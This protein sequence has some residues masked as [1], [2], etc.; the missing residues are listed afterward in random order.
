MNKI[1]VLMKCNLQMFQ[2]VPML[3]YQEDISDILASSTSWRER[4]Y[5][6]L[7]FFHIHLSAIKFD[8]FVI[9]FSLRQSMLKLLKLKILQTF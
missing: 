3:L 5:V 2:V 6:Q 8:Y 7:V 9:N 1:F 4:E